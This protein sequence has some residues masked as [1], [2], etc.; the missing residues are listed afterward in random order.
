MSEGVPVLNQLDLV[1]ADMEKALAFYRLLGL[2]I[3]EGTTS[4]PW[5]MHHVEVVLANGFE[6]AFDSFEMAE[7]Y[8]AAARPPAA[9]SAVLGFRLPTRE[10]V[11]ALHDVVK[12]AGHAIAQEPYDAFWGARYAIVVDPDGNHVGLMSPVDPAKRGAP[13]KLS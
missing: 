9:G 11:D 2:A 10:A 4:Q 7:Q 6:L 13:P 12:A 3:P 1:V 8:N 5:G